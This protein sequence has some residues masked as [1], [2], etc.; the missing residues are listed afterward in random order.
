[1]QVTLRP[2]S[3]YFVDAAITW[4]GKTCRFTGFYGEPRMELRKKSWDAIWYLRAQDNLPWICAGDFN[5]AMF[6]TDQLGGN[7]RSFAQME[8]FRD[9]LADCGLVDLG[10]SGY[11]Y[12]WDNK[13]DG[14]ENVQVRLDRATCNE[15]FIDLFP[16]TTVEHVMT[17]D[18]DHQALLIRAMETAPTRRP[19]G[20]R[21]FRFEEAWTRHETYDDMVAEAWA[22]SDV[23]AQ[24]VRACIQRLGRVASSMQRWARAVFGSIRGQISK[25]KS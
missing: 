21:P 6:Q 1:V 19:A 4:E 20:D 12:T 9:C 5:E 2:W 22:S 13:R 3:Q 16:G 11:P 24:G 25:L 8:D 15:S 14:A 10:F 23:G 17:E 18:S 7:N